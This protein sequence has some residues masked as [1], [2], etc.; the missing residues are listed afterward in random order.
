LINN[1]CRR[2]YRALSELPCFGREADRGLLGFL[3]VKK[4]RELLAPRE[5]AVL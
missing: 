2:C 3:E 1:Y 5:L 4:T